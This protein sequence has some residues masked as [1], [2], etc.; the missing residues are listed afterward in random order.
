MEVLQKI[1]VPYS[2]KS[3]AADICLQHHHLSFHIAHLLIKE[4]VNL[5]LERYVI[6]H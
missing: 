4:G 2:C 6:F 3:C 5:H 1:Y